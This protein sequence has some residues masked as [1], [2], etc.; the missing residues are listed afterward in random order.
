MLAPKNAHPEAWA[1]FKAGPWEETIDVR[2][3]IQRNY[4]PYT[5]DGSFL[6]PATEAT[7]RLWGEVMEGIKVEN[8]TH[9]PYKID[10]QTVSGITSHAPGYID[11]SLE[12]VVGLQTD[13]PLK[14]AIMPFGGL[15]MVQDS[16][17]IYETPL[18][19]TV[20]ETF[21]KYRKTHNQ[22]VF[23]VYT[24]DIRRCRKSGV[25]TGL[26]DA[27]GRGRIIG[28]YRRV[29]L[30]GIDR[31]MEDK[32]EQFNS[33][34]A[35]LEAGRN[36]EETIRRREEIHEQHKALGQMKEMAASYGFD[37]SGPARNA[38]EAVQWT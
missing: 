17:R 1:D 5:G 22:G 14:R 7:T 16:C 9:A 30:Y 15:K 4:T 3:F 8:R 34:Q 29:A 37:I 6:A 24:P 23:D 25:L 19:E 2:D 35:D 20:V 26:P 27:Y 33:L 10:A 11:R 32:V 31:L 13:E 18:S 38:R 36:L 21:T 28:D 12:K